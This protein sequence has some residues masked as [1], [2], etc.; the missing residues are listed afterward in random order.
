M[1]TIRLNTFETNS[2]SCHSLTITDEQTFNRF[3]NFEL[4]ID[5]METFHTIDEMYDVFIKTKDLRYIT[6]EKFK[7]AW[8][9]NSEKSKCHVISDIT[10]PDIHACIRYM[11]HNMGSIYNYGKFYDTFEEHRIVNGT[12]VVAFGYY[13][14][15]DS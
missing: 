3:K 15:D 5:D 2:S 10:D 1:R 6:K 7:E 11:Q 14:R 8:R 4:C 12:E 13:G 9:I